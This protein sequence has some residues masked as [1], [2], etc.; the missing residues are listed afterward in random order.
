V[1]T[2]P[3]FVTRR[4]F[5]RLARFRE[6]HPAITLVLST[7]LPPTDLDRKTPFRAM[8]GWH[9]SKPELFGKQPCYRPGCDT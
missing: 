3:A 5:P 6:A 4:L 9:R 8:K 7:W 1:Q 2:T